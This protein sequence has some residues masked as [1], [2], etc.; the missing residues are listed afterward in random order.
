[1]QI[2]DGGAFVV[3]FLKRLKEGPL[4]LL[5]L[6]LSRCLDVHEFQP[7]VHTH[8]RVYSMLR[9]DLHLVSHKRTKE[10]KTRKVRWNTCRLEGREKGEEEPMRGKSLVF[11]A[12]ASAQGRHRNH[13]VVPVM[14]AF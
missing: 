14:S 6:P 1:M 2:L 5:P 12:A 13:T 9:H 11:I 7:K 4:H 8:H 10:P 3:G